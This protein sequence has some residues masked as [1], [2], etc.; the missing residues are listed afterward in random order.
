M[1]LKNASYDMIPRLSEIWKEC[2]HDTDEYINLFMKNRFC[3]DE[4][5]VLTDNSGIVEGV[6]Y[7][8]PCKIIGSKQKVIYAYAGG[9]KS[10]SRGKGYYTAIVDWLRQQYFNTKTAVVLRHTQQLLDFYLIKGFKKTYFSKKTLIIPANEKREEITIYKNI[11]S[12]EY[13]TMRNNYFTAPETVLWNKEAINYA[14]TENIFCEGIC[15]KIK[16]CGIYYI[17]FG[18]VKNNI[19]YIDETTL[20]YKQVENISYSLCNYYNA[21]KIEFTS[22]VTDNFRGEIIVSALSFGLETL[23]L[24]EKTPPLSYD[25][26]CPSY[27]KTN[28][29][30]EG[31]INLM[32]V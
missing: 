14:L 32:L 9:V 23:P 31:W 13:E 17:L 25:V 18:R 19:L 2:F 8:L 30:N 3:P 20:N 22:P 26:E 5:L 6:I 21:S 24:S 4:T 28:S 10:E 16:Y 12:I 27:T 15:D 11:D 7:L 29:R 1:I